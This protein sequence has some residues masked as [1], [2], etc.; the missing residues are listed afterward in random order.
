M[1]RCGIVMSFPEGPS[2]QQLRTPVPKT[3][4]YLLFEDS[5]PN[6]HEYGFETRNLKH[7]VLGPSWLQRLQRHHEAMCLLLWGCLSIRNA[8]SWCPPAC[9]CVNFRMLGNPKQ[10]FFVD[11]CAL[12][13]IAT[14]ILC[15]G[16]GPLRAAPT[17]PCPAQ[18]CHEDPPAG[19]LSLN[20]WRLR[21]RPTY[22]FPN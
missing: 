21:S 4:N 19:A 14:R 8:V 17:N 7:W 22:S 13:E 6:N 10:T 9:P 18:T 5:G 1:G 12:S 2:T 11:V 15:G 3:I 16:M 20:L